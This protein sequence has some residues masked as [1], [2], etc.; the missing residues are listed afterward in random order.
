MLKVN[1][2][3]KYFKPGSPST[4]AGIFLFTLINAVFIL[5]TDILLRELSKIP[6]PRLLHFVQS[7]SQSAKENHL[8]KGG[9]QLFALCAK[10]QVRTGDPSLFRGMLYQLSYLGVAQILHYF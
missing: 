10:T 4:M 8:G 2:W 6:R 9:F 5:V 3:E 7:V 1:G